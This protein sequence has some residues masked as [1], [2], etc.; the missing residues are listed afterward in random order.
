M[1]FTNIRKAS[2][3]IA[4]IVIMCGFAFQSSAQT[5]MAGSWAMEV[6]TDQGRTTPELTLTKDGMKLS[7]SYSSDTLGNNQVSGT[8]DGNNVTMSFNANLQGQSVPVIYKGTVDGEGI[9]SG[10][11]DIAGGLLS[12]TFKGQKK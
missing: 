1:K 7:G 3:L 6:S 8:V 2:S 10:T 5:N 4:M 11:I 12:G 9:W